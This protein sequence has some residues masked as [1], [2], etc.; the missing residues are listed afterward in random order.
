MGALPKIVMVLII[1]YDINQVIFA[2][3]L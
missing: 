1:N 3:L 2:L